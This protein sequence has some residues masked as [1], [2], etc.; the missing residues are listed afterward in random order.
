MRFHILVVSAVIWLLFTGTGYA[1][2][3]TGTLDGY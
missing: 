1:Q 2:T 3:F